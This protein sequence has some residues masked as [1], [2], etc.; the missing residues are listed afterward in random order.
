M[1][2][3]HVNKNIFLSIKNESMVTLTKYLKTETWKGV[4]KEINLRVINNYKRQRIR[5]IKIYIL[6]LDLWHT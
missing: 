4:H 2:F 1:Y 3:C 6:T 5:Q